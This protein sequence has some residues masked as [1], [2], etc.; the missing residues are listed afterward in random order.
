VETLWEYPGKRWSKSPGNPHPEG[1]AG[2]AFLLIQ[3]DMQGTLS[4]ANEEV[5]H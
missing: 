1:L 5:L 3:G 4:W 2:P